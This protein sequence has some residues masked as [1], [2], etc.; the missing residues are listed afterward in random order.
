M[1]T[2][3]HNFKCTQFYII[4]VKLNVI[5]HKFA[6]VLHNFVSKIC[7]IFRLQEQELR[8]YPI[9]EAAQL[10]NRSQMTWRIC[11]GNRQIGLMRNGSLCPIHLLDSATLGASLCP[12]RALCPAMPVQY[13]RQAIAQYLIYMCSDDVSATD[14]QRQRAAAGNLRLSPVEIDILM[15]YLGLT[16]MQGV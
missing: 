7:K 9:S 12:W 6:H 16:T 3:L 1:Y 8:F 2:I 11:G 10:S 13:M 14:E 15:N 5:L 4:Y